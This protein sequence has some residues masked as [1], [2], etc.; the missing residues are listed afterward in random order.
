RTGPGPR[1]GASAPSTPRRPRRRPRPARRRA[2]WPLSPRVRT[3]PGSSSPRP[4]PAAASSAAGPERLPDHVDDE[5]ADESRAAV[6]SVGS[7]RTVLPPGGLRRGPGARAPPRPGH[8]GQVGEGRVR[9]GRVKEGPA[10]GD[11]EGLLG[12]VAGGARPGSLMVACRRERELGPLN[13]GGP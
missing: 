13:R 12:D 6:R 8:V 7:G 1:G 5:E 10:Q 2:S 3:R 9:D 11:E 4:E